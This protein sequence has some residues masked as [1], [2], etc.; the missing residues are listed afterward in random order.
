MFGAFFR[1]KGL[2]NPVELS[3]FKT[4]V[5]Q[6]LVQRIRNPQQLYDF[7][8]EDID[9]A[10]QGNSIAQQYV[11]SLGLFKVEYK[12][13]L[14]QSSSMDEDDSALDYLNNK[15]SPL[16]IN[17]L[18]LDKAILVRCQILQ[19]F[20]KDN[21]NLLDEVRLK[22][23][24]YMLN[25]AEERHVRERKADEWIEVVNYFLSYSGKKPVAKDLTDIVP[26]KNWTEFGFY[27][28]LYQ[29]IKDYM[30][31]NEEIPHDIM[32]P[33]N[34]ALRFSYGGLYAQ[35][36][37]TKEV[38]DSISHPFNVRM[39]MVGRML[40]KEEQVNFQ[41]DSLTQAV[42][43]INTSYDN[44]VKRHTTSLIVQAARNDLC[45]KS[46]LID[47]AEASFIPDFADS[48]NLEVINS[49]FVT[50]FFTMGGWLPDEDA[51]AF[52]N[53]VYNFLHEPNLTP[54]IFLHK[55]P[56]DI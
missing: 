16:L 9:G 11:N 50:M 1:K 3:K 10:S 28:D 43:W 37:C 34:Y 51:E 48:L 5:Y 52:V 21:K 13:A 33:L 47:A 26:R 18:G 40:S 17:E 42:K 15:I 45:L 56:A 36:L 44:K 25:T 39:I 55:M 29:D 14:Y 41:E 38:F 12:G 49:D 2:K 46:A 20:F 6:G 24:R 30:S 8:M 19:K 32:T 7:F 31:E 27:Y 22:H 53:K 35:G 23:A 54:Y 4:E